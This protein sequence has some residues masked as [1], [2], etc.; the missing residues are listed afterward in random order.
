MRNQRQM[1]SESLL[2]MKMKH[3]EK[4]VDKRANMVQRDA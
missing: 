3:P 2:L 4:L 1:K